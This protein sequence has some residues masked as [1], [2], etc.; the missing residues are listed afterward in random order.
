MLKIRDKFSIIG[1]QYLK[2]VEL[3]VRIDSYSLNLDIYRQEIIAKR[4]LYLSKQVVRINYLPSNAHAFDGCLR[5]SAPALLN[6]ALRTS[7]G[8]FNRV[9]LRLI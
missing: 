6:F 3:H 2:H 1:G 9:S 5:L 7:S 4:L 8:G